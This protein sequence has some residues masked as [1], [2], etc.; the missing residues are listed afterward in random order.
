MIKETETETEERDEGGMTYGQLNMLTVVLSEGREL[1]TN[2]KFQ[3]SH[4]PTL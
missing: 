2:S 1:P 4:S 3:V